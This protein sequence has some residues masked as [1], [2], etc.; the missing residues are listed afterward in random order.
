MS[1]TP[2]LAES[3]IIIGH[4]IAAFG[5]LILGIWQMLSTKGTI[6]HRRIGYIWAVLMMVVAGSSLWI[7]ELRLVGPFSPIHLLSILVLVNVPIAVHAARRSNIK[8]HRTYMRSL[9][10]L[11]LIVTGAFTLMPGRVM[12]EVLF[13]S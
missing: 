11:A 1:L 13:G 7:H 6:P 2:L 3:W 8:K 10:F 5:A 12:H 9:F 4:V